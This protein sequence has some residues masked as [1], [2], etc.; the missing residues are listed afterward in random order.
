MGVNSQI[1]LLETELAK[2]HSI[3]ESLK[4]LIFSIIV[5]KT[6]KLEDEDDV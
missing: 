3:N 6:G 4:T 5:Q 2:K 1:D